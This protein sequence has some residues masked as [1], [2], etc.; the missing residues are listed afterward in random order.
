MRFRSILLG[1]GI[2]LLGGLVVPGCERSPVAGTGSVSEQPTLARSPTGFYSPEQARALENATRLL[3]EALGDRAAREALYDALQA[4]LVTENKLVLSDFLKEIRGQSILD[5]AAARSGRGRD[6]I[7]RIMG[8]LPG[9]DLYIPY[10]EQ[11]MT[12]RPSDPIAVATL[13]DKESPVVAH[14]AG[15]STVPIDRASAAPPNIAILLLGP[16]ELKLPRGR[17]MNILCPPTE[18]G[19]GGGGGGGDGG[20]ESLR[21]ET[22]ALSAYVCDNNFCGEGNEFEFRSSPVEPYTVL[23]RCTSLYP[24]RT[25]KVA[26]YCS[27]TLVQHNDPSEVGGIWMPVYETDAWPNPDDRWWDFLTPYPDTAFA[28]VPYIRN[29]GLGRQSFVLF[30][31][32]DGANCTPYCYAQVGLVFKWP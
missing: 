26:D 22:I 3:A 19:G 2:L 16:A 17:P 9:T 15:G 8:A 24:G 32:P 29:N 25:Y 1:V 12:W 28:S 11:R 20:G 6:E 5:H 31:Y 30:Q 21:I 13:V 7:A 10:P 23:W 4:S 14:L 18:C 27:T